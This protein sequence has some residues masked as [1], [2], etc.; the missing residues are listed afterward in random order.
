MKM[1]A[2]L[3]SV[4][5]E[6]FEQEGEESL[7]VDYEGPGMLQQPLATLL[8]TPAKEKPAEKVAELFRIDSAKAA[9]GRDYF[10]SL[11]CASC[12]T[13]NA[14]GSPI[15]AKNSAAL[16]LLISMAV[17]AASISQAKRRRVTRMSNAQNNRH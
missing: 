14:G 16:R 1:T 5:V 3:H 13:L 6:Y 2:G 12:H 17:V 4:V 11:G 10:A 7:Q 15:T 8:T 9:K